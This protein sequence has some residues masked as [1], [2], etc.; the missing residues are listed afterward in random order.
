MEL[1]ARNHGSLRILMESLQNE[2]ISHCLLKKGM[3]ADIEL[4]DGK[5]CA[6]GKEME[7]VLGYP[8]DGVLVTPEGVIKAGRAGVDHEGVAVAQT[9]GETDQQQPQADQKPLPTGEIA[10]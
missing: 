3:F 10:A 6:A 1:Q 4:P 5:T 2:L 7:I 9:A 8:M